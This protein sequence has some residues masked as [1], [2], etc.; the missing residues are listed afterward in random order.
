MNLKNR[1]ITLACFLGVLVAAAIQLRRMESS[2]IVEAGKKGEQR[3]LSLAI[4]NEFSQVSQSLTRNCRTFVATGDK[5]Y[6]DEYQHLL[7]WR[8]GTAPRPKYVNSLLYRGERKPQLDIME[9]LNFSAEE[10]DLLKKSGHLSAALVSTEVQ[11]MATIKQGKIAPGPMKPLQ[12]ESPQDFALRIV[13]DDAYHGE[14]QKIL[15]PVNEFLAKLES[16]TAA[17]VKAYQGQADRYA[18]FSLIMQL[19]IAA[20]IVGMVIYLIRSVFTPLSKGTKIVCQIAGGDYP[21]VSG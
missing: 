19:M 9:E 8:S 17:E 20:A 13:F 5:R 1:F 12:G 2:A 3:Y 11:A 21:P 10:L 16:R 18:T 7:D 6:E 14:V 15:A 4:A